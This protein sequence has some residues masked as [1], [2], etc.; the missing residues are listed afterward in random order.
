MANKVRLTAFFLRKAKRLLK[1]YHSLQS[2]LKKLEKD[3]IVNPKM[4][5][6]MVQIFTK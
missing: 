3:L 4:E 6:T 2:S 1:K 5:I